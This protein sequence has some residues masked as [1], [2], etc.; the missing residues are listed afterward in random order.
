MTDTLA[1]IIAK[2]ARIEAVETDLEFA[3]RRIAELEAA[4]AF[5]DEKCQLYGAHD[6]ARERIRIVLDNPSAILAAYR[7]Q[8][9]RETLE[10][11]MRL[12]RQGTG[13]RYIWALSIETEFAP[14]GDTDAQRD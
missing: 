3:K 5:I 2:D 9:E 7:A 1:V 10:K 13:G 11:V 14:K 12:S 4:L 6:A 8:V